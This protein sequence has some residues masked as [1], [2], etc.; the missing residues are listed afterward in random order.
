MMQGTQ[1]SNI[2]VSDGNDGGCAHN[3]VCHE[4]C[5]K[6]WDV[7]EGNSFRTTA[8]C[9]DW[10]MRW[11]EVKVTPLR[12]HPLCYG[13]V[14]RTFQKMDHPLFEGIIQGYTYA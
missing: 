4:W 7:S 8:A 14:H 5:A 11:L 10:K 9:M 1:V 2:N 13:I 6:R 12:G 3:V